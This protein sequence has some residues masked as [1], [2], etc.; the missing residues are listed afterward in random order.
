MRIAWK[1]IALIMLL[2]LTGIALADEWADDPY[3]IKMANRAAQETGR[4]TKVVLLDTDY[5]RPPTITEKIM[6]NGFKRYELPEPR[7][8]DPK[9]ALYMPALPP[10]QLEYKPVRTTPPSARPSPGDGS[11]EPGSVE[12]FMA[13]DVLVSIPSTRPQRQPHCT[14]GDD[15]AIYAVWGEEIDANNNAIM[16]SKSTDAGL[17][18]STAIVVDNVGT[19]Y[20]PRIAVWGTGFSAIVHVVYNYV[21]WHVQDYYDTTGTYLYS[22]TIFEGDVYYCRSNSGGSTFG[23]YQAIANSDINILFIAINYDEGGA[24]INVDEYDNVVI[25]YYGQSDEGHIMSMA[26]M[27]LLIILYEGLPPFW[28]DYTWYEV[29]M[30]ASINHGGTFNSK[31]RIMHEWFMDNSLTGSDI[32]G[33]GSGATLHAI[34]TATGILSLGSATAYYRQVINPFF[35]PSN[36]MDNFVSDGYAVP[37]GVRV[38]SL[39]NPRAGI[40]DISGYGY[41]VYYSRSMDGGHTWPLPTVVAASTMDEWEPKLRLDDAANTF[42][43]WSDER[44]INTDIWTVWSEDGGW[45]LRSDQHRVN[46][47]TVADQLWPGI[48]MFLSDTTRRLDVVW[49]DTWSDPDG[50]IYYNGA[51]WWRTNLNAMLH[52]SLA[53]PMGG[54][55]YLHYRSFD[56]QIDRPVSTG[57]H[58]IY[59]DPGTQICISRLSSGSDGVERW[60]YDEVDSFCVTP[61]VPG[62]TYDVI[63][64]NQYY[65]DFSTTIGNAPACTVSSMPSLPFTYEYFEFTEVEF[66]DFV[67]WANVRGEYN[68]PDDYPTPPTGPWRWYCPEPSGLVLSP[69]VSPIYYFQYM[70]RFE[71]PIKLNDPECTHSVPHF[72]MDERYYGGV[73][74]GGT[75]PLYDWADCGSFYQYEDPRIVSESQ[76]WDITS[77]ASGVV[78]GLGP[79]QPEVYHQW[80][81]TINLIGPYL[82]ENPT[83][84]ETLYVGGVRTGESSLVGVYQ[85]W[86]DCGSSLWMG[87]FTT[88]GWVARDPRIF[89]PVT[90]AFMAIIRY[91]NVVSVTLQNDFGYGFLLADGDSVLSGFPLGWAPTSEHIICA[92]T[93]Q[94]FGATRYVFDHWSDYG[95]TCHTVIPVGDTTWTA[96]FNKQ[97]YL[98][99]DSD[100][101]TPWGEGWYD[102]GAIVNFGVEGTTPPVGGIRY[103]FLGWEGAGTGSYTGPDTSADVTMNNPITEEAEWETQFYI[104]L[105]F[106]GTDTLVPTQSGDGWYTGAS[107][108]IITTDSIIGDDGPDDTLRY[109]FDHWE[110]T[111]AGATFGNAYHASTQ[112]F[113]DRPYTCTAVY[114]RQWSFIVE[115][116]DTGLGSPVPDLGKHWFFEGDT[117]VAYVSSPDGGMYC[118]GYLGYGSLVDGDLAFASFEIY[119]PSGIIWQWGNQFEFDVTSDPYE[120]IMGMATPDPVAGHYYYVPGTIDTFQVAEFTP[121][122]GGTRYACTGWTGSGPDPAADGGDSNIV[123]IE[124]TSSGELR[125]QFEQQLRFVV[126]SPYDTPD[127]TEGV[128]WYESGTALTPSVDPVDG[129]WRCIGYNLVIGGMPTTGFGYSFDITVSVP[130]S[131]VWVWINVYD[132]ESLQV[133]SDHGPVA[134]PAGGWNYFL[135][136][137][138][139]DAWAVMYDLTEVDDGVRYKCVGWEG[140]GPVPT[141]GDSTICPITMDASGTLTWTWQTQYLVHVDC[142]HDDPEYSLNGVFWN[143]LDP[144]H[145]VWVPDGAPF[146]VRVNHYADTLAGDSLVFCSGWHGVGA[147]LFGLDT[148]DLDFNFNVIDPCTIDFVWTSILY[149]LYV[150]SDYGDPIPDDTT[151]WLPGATVDAFVT[152]PYEPGTPDGV[153]WLCTGWTGTGS[154]PP[155]GTGAIMSFEIYDTSS[156]TWLWQEQYRLTILSWPEIYDSPNPTVGDHW[157]NAGDSVY[158]YVTH[159]VWDDPDTMYCIGFNGA[160]SAPSRSPQTEFGFYLDEASAVEWLWYPRDTVALLQVVSDYDSPRPYGLT[161]WLLGDT[162]DARVDSTAI[163]GAS[164]YECIGWRGSGSPPATGDTNR[165]VFPIW[166]DSYLEWLWSNVYEFTVINAMGY[167]APDPI[168][169]TYMHSAGSWVFGQMLDHPYWTGTDTMYCVGFRGSG[170]LP[171]FD[172][173]TDFGFNITTNSSC[174]WRWSDEAFTLTVYSAYGS[175]WP[176]GTTYWI[177]GTTVPS[178]HV[179]SA[180]IVSP[181]IRA[182]C[183]GWVG[184]G[185]TPATGSGY[186]IPDFNILD[187]S[188]ITWEWQMQYGFTVTNEGPGFGGFDTP[189]PPVGTSWYFEGDTVVAYITDNPAPAP[190][191]SMYCIG[192]TGSGSAPIWSPQDSIWFEIHEISTCNWHWLDEDTIARLTV[193]SDHGWPPSPWGITY[194]PLFSFVDASVMPWEE[195]DSVTR[196]FCTGFDLVS[197]SLAIDT[198]DTFNN[199]TFTIVENTDLWWN[200]IGQ[201]YLSL[202]Y[203]GLPTG[204]PTLTGEGWYGEGDTAFYECETPVL[205]AGTY[206]GFV[207]WNVIP[208]LT[209]TAMYLDTLFWHNWQIM[210]T[211]YSA[212]A[213]YAPGVFAVIQKD[214][215]ENDEGWISVDAMTYDSTAL[216]TTWWG[217]GSYH[218]LEVPNLDSTAT[219][220]RYRYNHWSDAGDREH[221]VGPITMDTVFTAFYDGQIMC[222]VVKS[223][224]HEWGYI[225]ADGDTFW[226]EASHIFWWSPGPPHEI[227]VSSP[228]SSGEEASDT[229]RYFFR[230]WSDGGDI[231]HWTDSISTPTSYVAYYDQR[232]KVHLRRE[233]EHAYGWFLYEADTVRGVNDVKFWADSGETPTIEVSEFNIADHPGFTEDSVWTFQNWSDA[234]LRRHEL[235]PL[236]APGI[237]TAYYLAAVA[238]LDFDI[239]PT[240]WTV[241]DSSLPGNY[242][243][244]M[245]TEDLITATN[246]GNVPVDLGF[247]ITDPGPWVPGFWANID[248][249]VLRLHI[250]D[251]PTPP[252]SFSYTQDYVKE[253]LQWATN[254]AFGKF[255]PCGNNILPPPYIAPD[256]SDN[257]W[258]QFVTPTHS[259]GESVY[260]I[261]QVITL[262]AMVRYHMP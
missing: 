185:S 124:M 251:E 75:T 237:Y 96:Y 33:T 121:D 184:T 176:H 77:G 59:H 207:H 153:R 212:T 103:T 48:G 112:V 161:A 125:W 8:I 106:T 76:R 178:A 206:Y 9:D 227:G 105:D 110:S 211:A 93:P 60:I 99:I 116:T 117:I 42:L 239:S 66:T 21:D 217:E 145:D 89:D 240:S 134:P 23:H 229:I 173:H 44:S 141:V 47:T 43:S 146:Y 147:S 86:S 200:W 255:G 38:D 55:V 35:S 150:Y 162:V 100:Y 201:Y 98:D 71:D 14:T 243:V 137:T 171:P 5:V 139:F 177:P 164:V 238:I 195:V 74:V 223:P 36:N 241:S 104:E 148:T 119:S 56:V 232:M 4:I 49:W 53:N 51:N 7:T 202:F 109:V 154:A 244:T 188:T 235:P 19:N 165:I 29:D 30:R 73:N 203:D 219:G 102:E 78:D 46:Q 252:T 218:L 62:N 115:T 120:W 144:S 254:G 32:E 262:Q 17:S 20:S 157:Y 149:P 84:C 242:T 108:P 39:G 169:G 179:D 131:L 83:Y 180:V 95:D 40:T 70:A 92:I 67:G 253:D 174:D 58:I 63:Y 187:H 152:S 81:P 10:T 3:T 2:I 12:E 94:V 221:W 90:S 113:V 167:G 222:P 209:D 72:T 225:Y 186:V 123:I 228:D 248:M 192:M 247:A 80:R 128:H 170:N 181:G 245:E 45:T 27:L 57:Y 87:E 151:Y 126:V 34:Y 216:W 143:D 230:E 25:S 11:F 107:M 133:I 256:V 156:I 1:S 194:W 261:E 258:M 138:L 191:D 234:G 130:C 16:F 135:R 183:T 197:E 41:D 82:P 129:D 85:P 159:P 220:E 260:G 168:P 22:D 231:F 257:L 127:P 158:G 182:Y 111:P 259:T 13:S 208:E 26:I 6:A 114:R 236:E 189:Q 249:F 213:Y 142:E 50:D 250:N 193:I 91:G 205:D 198:S 163:V 175:P 214:P 166:T 31:H 204:V 246:L 196:Y 226:D 54:Y 64:Y 136:G 210:D 224:R 28:I 69:V 215:E 37:A 52:D 79:F 15:G 88:L 132:C 18:W 118:T 160:G 199:V 155:S 97:Y 140:T 190:Y 68:Y 101:G 122:M 24:D 233:P 61:P 65:T 172:P